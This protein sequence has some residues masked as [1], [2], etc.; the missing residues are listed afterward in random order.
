MA[1]R[2]VSNQYLHMVNR[3]LYSCETKGLKKYHAESR[4]MIVLK[5]LLEYPTFTLY[6]VEGVSYKEKGVRLMEI[7]K[8]FVTTINCMDGRVQIPVNEYM[9]SEFSADYVDTITEAGPNKILADADNTVLLDSIK[10]RYEV[11][12]M[13]HDSKVVAI[14]GHYDCGGNPADKD[15][16]LEQIKKACELV[17]T[18]NE[19]VKVI[20]LW[21]DESWTVN[22]VLS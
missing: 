13:K 3:S 9:V 20:G 1:I 18:W 7:G 19:K 10:T 12:T 4:K 5:K 11:S 6:T 15:K 14:V 2:N 17:S 22:V 8:T 16:Q 21:V